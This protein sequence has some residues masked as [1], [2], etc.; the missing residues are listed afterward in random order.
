M[1]KIKG[2]PPIRSYEGVWESTFAEGIIAKLASFQR[3][4]LFYFKL[5]DKNTFDDLNFHFQVL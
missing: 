3:N 4:L 2:A 5:F 1:L